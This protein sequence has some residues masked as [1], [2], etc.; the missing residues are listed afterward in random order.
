MTSVTSVTFVTSR[1]ALAVAACS[2][3]VAACS[4]G[5]ASRSASTSA[6]TSTTVSQAD[7][8]ADGTA[9]TS[10]SDPAA[11]AATTAS[12]A[13]A[14]TDAVST[15]PASTAPLTTAGD[16]AVGGSVPADPPTTEPP[17]TR[18]PIEPAPDLTAAEAADR[19]LARTALITLADF[20]D[21]WTE[22]PDE[23]DADDAET[24]AFE[25]EFD[26]CLDRDD[27]GVGDR[28]ERLVVSTGDFH[29]I[30]DNT[31][32]VAHEVVLAPDEATA[33]SAMAEV[34][35]DGAEACLGD[36]IQRFY[37][38]SFA[39]DPALAG[40]VVGQVAV[41]RTERER[42]ADRT[43]GVLLEVPLELD[44]QAITQYLEILYQRD[45]RALSELSF[46]SLGERF[47][48]DGY[49]LLSDDVAVALAAIG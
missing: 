18:P 49:D 46:S 3:M 26:E 19:E 13:T 22:D 37:I 5:D 35:I 48:R 44:D 2:L 41:T 33:L 6:S 9:P 28:L 39:D 36:V 7:S 40:I 8:T 31:P 10:T 27:D 45:G 16:S 38:A 42:P 24:A 23:D 25:A 32:N 1:L 14:S 30:G 12:E 43:V 47:S 29:P 15:A 21:G 17:A 20:P 4:S 34:V 11:V